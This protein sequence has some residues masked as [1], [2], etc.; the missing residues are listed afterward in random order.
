MWDDVSVELPEAAERRLLLERVRAERTAVFEAQRVASRK[1]RRIDTLLI[2]LSTGTSGSLW[3]LC[4]S[5]GPEWLTTVVKW[6]GAAIGTVCA[7]LTA[8]KEKVTN[9]R[10]LAEQLQQQNAALEKLIHRIEDGH[11]LSGISSEYRAI[12]GQLAPIRAS[13]DLPGVDS[14]L[15]DLK[16]LIR[17]ARREELESAE[18]QPLEIAA[19]LD[20]AVP[21]DGASSSD[22]EQRD[23]RSL[24]GAFVE[25]KQQCG[26]PTEGFTYDKFE[27][28]LRKNRDTLIAEHGA[29]R[30]K[31]STY[32]KDGKAALK[33][34][35]VR[36]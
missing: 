4:A 34:T 8:Y 26:E 30:V 11:H 24:Y 25:L 32:V 2:T 28:T 35:P 5:A 6:V 16:Q 3:F 33:A 7:V 29:K 15:V 36:A 31:F 9:F 18:P 1:A 10:A 21:I 27:M 17:D 13:L 22:T 14:H 19:P 23:W 12:K 20:A